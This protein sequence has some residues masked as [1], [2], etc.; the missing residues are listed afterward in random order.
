[1]SYMDLPKEQDIHTT[2]YGTFKGIDAS[3]NPHAIDKEHA[4]FGRN[5]ILGDTGA[6]EKRPGFRT[7]ANLSG[8]INGIYPY[9]HISGDMFII[10]AGT[11]I[12]SGSL[13]DASIT[14]VLLFSGVANRPGTSFNYPVNNFNCL[15]ILTGSEY[16]MFN[17]TTMQHVKDIVQQPVIKRMQLGF[18]LIEKRGRNILHD[19][20]C[21]MFHVDYDMRI[22][23]L[24]YDVD[25]TKPF[26]IIY[27]YFP[28]D[29]PTKQSISIPQYT[30]YDS[31]TI[32]FTVEIANMVP[33]D[34]YNIKIYYS[35]LTEHSGII[36]QC[37]KFALYGPEGENRVFVSGYPGLP[38]CDFMSEEFD[39]MYFTPESMTIFG[40]QSNAIMGYSKIGDE[41]MIVK[42]D[43]RNDTSVYLRSYNELVSGT[44]YSIKSSVGGAG[45][46]GPYCLGILEDEPLF[47]SHSG[48][49]AVTTRTITAERAL[50]NRSYYI[51]SVLLQ[52]PDLYHA[53][54]VSYKH[55]Y[56]IAAGGYIFVLDSRQ[57]SSGNYQLSDILYGSFI[58]QGVDVCCFAVYNDVL[59]IG[60]EHGEIKR[61]SD[62]LT[63]TMRFRDD[64]TAI[65]AVWITKDD[66]DEL[67]NIAKTLQKKGG[68]L[69]LGG[70]DATSATVAISVDGKE[71]EIIGEFADD[72]S[73]TGST[74][75]FYFDKKV[76][77]YNS[78]RFKV[79][80]DKLGENI[81]LYELCKTYTTDSFAK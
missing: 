1:M 13:D 49:L 72:G 11:N 28:P 69:Q 47:L 81:I 9:R 18:N 12:F 43:A 74:L 78:I 30:F 77:R 29:E 61:L 27:D 31:K 59:Y 58:W 51:D 10:H 7:L 38:A 80:N 33:E 63:G 68:M 16:L 21:E 32:Y 70:A 20:V 2:V 66:D 50:Q 75:R 22:L 56:L 67:P 17:G 34:D 36:E 71:F 24:E 54:A 35:P 76:K 52:Q 8:R 48:V 46:I 14:P 65:E 6:L 19:S 55:Y 44:V 45:A 3:H 4:S 25:M 64:D 5:M 23:T 37:D 53:Q 40:D 60:T 15:F 79:S 39:P 57:K 41:L 73:Q 42:G 26:Q 62:D